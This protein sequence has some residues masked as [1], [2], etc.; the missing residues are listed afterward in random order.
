M[1]NIHGING[2]HPHPTSPISHNIPNGPFMNTPPV[3]KES[4]VITWVTSPPPNHPPVNF[5]R[6]LT[7]PNRRF[8]NPL[9]TQP[10]SPQLDLGP[11]KVKDWG[12]LPISSSQ[13]SHA[14]SELS[15]SEGKTR[16]YIFLFPIL[17]SLA[18]SLFMLPPLLAS[19]SPAPVLTLV[20]SG[21]TYLLYLLVSPF[22]RVPHCGLVLSTQAHLY[23]T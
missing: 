21:I 2:P 3:P 7:H 4:T 11:L 19:I 13:I 5:F 12:L 1:T 15:R 23:S 14:T 6:K 8:A 20:F 10:R 16:T 18:S 22:W 17:A 9:F